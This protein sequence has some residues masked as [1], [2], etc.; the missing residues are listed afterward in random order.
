MLHTL[1]IYRKTISNNEISDNFNSWSESVKSFGFGNYLNN[2]LP[3]G[4]KVIPP[5]NFM[6]G[7]I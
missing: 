4:K 1:Q 7:G 5:Q 6:M 2:D 3:I